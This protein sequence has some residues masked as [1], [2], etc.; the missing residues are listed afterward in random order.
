MLSPWPP[1]P[2]NRRDLRWYDGGVRI[3]RNCLWLVGVLAF[4]LNPSFACG[5]A[6]DDFQF[7]VNEMRGAVEGT[8][9]AALTFPDGHQSSVVFTISQ[10]AQQASAATILRVKPPRTSWVASAY[11]C[12][13]R[14]FVRSASACVP[15]SSMPLDGTFVSGDATFQ[16]AAIRG[17]LNVYGLALS[18]MST[19]VDLHL[20]EAAE[21]QFSV[22][23]DGTTTNAHLV[24]PA[25]GTATGG[26]SVT[27][28]RVSK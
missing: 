27:L 16:S 2:I 17:V 10:G 5:G 15:V 12:S 3:I 6:E 19:S 13:D 18:N 8:W 24:D 4:F 26:G 11:A 21:L 9:Q 1:Q 22:S 14:T 23:P 7:G 20:G 28:V 25:S